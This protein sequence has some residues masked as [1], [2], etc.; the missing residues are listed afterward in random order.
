MQ[1]ALIAGEFL[2]L[3]AEAQDVHVGQIKWPREKHIVIFII[4]I[5]V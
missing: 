1:S 2:A 4:V 3:Y 5:V